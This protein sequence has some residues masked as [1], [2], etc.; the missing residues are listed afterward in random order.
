MDTSLIQVA[1]SAV[2]EDKV[3]KAEKRHHI[4]RHW[5]M[6]VS[7]AK[8]WRFGPVFAKAFV[9]NAGSPTYHHLRGTVPI[10]RASFSPYCTYE[11]PEVSA[12]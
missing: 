1:S 7:S 11:D 12:G 2:A 4:S 10:T 3:G 9:P 5:R 8:K 6:V